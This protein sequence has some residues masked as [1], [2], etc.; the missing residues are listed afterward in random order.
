MIELNVKREMDI[1]KTDLHLALLPPHVTWDNMIEYSSS[2]KL[3]SYIHI[4][5]V[6]K[7]FIRC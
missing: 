6:C 3:F 4:T 7:I 2:H 1:M 5:S